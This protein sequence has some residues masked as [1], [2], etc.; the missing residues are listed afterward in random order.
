E[1]GIATVLGDLAE[2]E[3]GHGH[4]EEAL[5]AVSE[6]LGIDLRG[7]NATTI[8]YGY[9]NIAAYR[10]ALNDLTGAR[11]AAREGLRFARQVRNEQLIAVALQHLAVLAGLGGDARR[12]AQLLGYMNAQYTA[13]GV[14]REPTEQWG[15]DKLM[16]ALREAL[17]AD[18]IA[19]LG[20]EGAAW[21]EDPAVEEALKI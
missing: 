13:L 1:S 9:I 10:I 7:K 14:Q 2:L 16:A 8:A 15:Y 18:E 6:A 4:P 3:F 12:G 19:T 11:D 17:S 21:S 5:R 20:A